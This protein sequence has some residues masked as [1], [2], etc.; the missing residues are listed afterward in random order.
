MKKDVV[1]RELEK[2]A[3]I[4]REFGADKVLLF[5]SCLEDIESASDIDIAVSGIKPR[6][7]FRYYG[8]VSMAVQH[9]VDIVD[10]DDI[11]EH[12]HNRVLS[13]GRVV[14]EKGA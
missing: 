8:K 7:F 14:Y 6:D 11:R 9:E 12:L 1:E 13:K 3:G 5:G 10:L 2:I 4:S